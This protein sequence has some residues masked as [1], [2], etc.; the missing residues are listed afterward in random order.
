[1]IDAAAAA[2]MVTLDVARA[3]GAGPACDPNSR[4]RYPVL[5][6]VV[7]KPRQAVL[8]AFIVLDA[9]PWLAAT[10]NQ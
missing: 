2:C 10:Y 3:S 8:N 7:E 4:H 1:M 6:D 9:G 5:A